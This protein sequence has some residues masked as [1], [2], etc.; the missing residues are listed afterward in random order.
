MLSTGCALLL[1]LIVVVTSVYAQQ[2]PG[3]NRGATSA[4]H[5]TRRVHRVKLPKMHRHS[6][7]T[8]KPRTSVSPHE[9]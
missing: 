6:A 7:P 8:L 9:Q 4:M 1:L 2:R 5:N 3:Y